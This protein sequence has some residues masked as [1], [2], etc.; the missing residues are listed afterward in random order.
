MG[1]AG[2]EPA[3]SCLQGW[4]AQAQKAP[5]IGAPRG[6]NDRAAGCGLRSFGLVCQGFGQNR[7]RFAQT[8]TVERPRLLG[9]LPIGPRGGPGR[10]VLPQSLELSSQDGTST[11]SLQPAAVL[12]STDDLESLEETFAIMSDRSLRAQIR[13]SGKGAAAGGA[14]GGC[15]YSQSLRRKSQ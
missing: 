9:G 10:G 5:D 6:L 2:F 12:V 4:S 14:G 7:G 15:P 13:A 11:S 3:T 1:R 8:G